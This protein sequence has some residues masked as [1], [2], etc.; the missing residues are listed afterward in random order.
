[1]FGGVIGLGSS[2]SANF[3]FCRSHRAGSMIGESLTSRFRY[4]GF[5][6]FHNCSSP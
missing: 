6:I 5:V 1:M 2:F 4:V 3:Y